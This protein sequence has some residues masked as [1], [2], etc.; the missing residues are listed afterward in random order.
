[1]AT[2][3]SEVKLEKSKQLM[4]VICDTIC[5]SN[6]S[7]TILDEIDYFVVFKYISVL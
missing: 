5:S 4:T 2:K 3:I 6:F 1:M 7:S